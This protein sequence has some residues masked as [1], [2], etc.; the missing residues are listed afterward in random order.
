MACQVT[1]KIK[2]AKQSTS[3][4]EQRAETRSKIIEAGQKAF[5]EQGF[6]GASTRDIAERAGITQGLLTYH[7]KSKEELWRAVV[8]HM[9]ADL[10][11]RLDAEDAKLDRAA[12]SETER[13]REAVRNYVRFA[14]ERPEQFQIMMDAGKS[15]N[16]RMAWMVEHHL[17]RQYNRFSNDGG[18]EA[19]KM[20]AHVY[21]ILAGAGSVVFAVAPEVRALTGQ[22]PHT[23]QFVEDHANFL[24]DLLVPQM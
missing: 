24:A 16:D 3:R 15:E 11:V 1:Y 19:Q 21:Y 23:Q 13:R 8:D 14:A 9:F 18:V 4:A 17:T 6:V 5:A 12:I 7:F 20:R 22:E 10:N 2:M